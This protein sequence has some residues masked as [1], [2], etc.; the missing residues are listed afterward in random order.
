MRLYEVD[1]RGVL[2]LAS[3]ALIALGLTS[4]ALTPAFAQE[5]KVLRVSQ[6][7]DASTMD[8]QMQGSMVDTSVLINMF[9]MLTYRAD[10]GQ[11]VPGLAT[12]W[13]AL[14]DTTWRFKLRDD[15]NFHNGEPFNAAAVKFSIDRIIKP[16]TK[17]PIVELRSVK[18][19]VVVDE[20]TVDVITT[21]PDPI[22]P[23]KLSLFG[24]VMIPPAYVTEVGDEGFAAHPIGTGPF[25]FVEWQRNQ[26]VVMEAN[27][28]Y[29]DGRPAIDK[30]IFRPIPDTS[31]ALAAI[32]AGELD[33]VAGLSADAAAQITGDPEINVVAETGVRAFF[34]VL[35]TINGGPLT[36]KRVRQ[37]LNHA[38]N[39]PEL[40]EALYGG[41]AHQISTLVARQSFGFDPSLAPYEHDLEKAKSLLAEAGY[42]DGFTVNL[43]AQSSNGDF[44][45]AISG[46]LAQVGVTA[47][48]QLHDGGNFSAMTREN[49]AAALSPMWFQ[50]ATG[51][52]MDAAS[53]FQSYIKPDRVFSQ[54][55]NP[56]ASAL[57][58]IGEQSVDPAVR[59]EAYNKLQALLIE[60]APFLF[61]YQID[62]LYAVKSNVTWNANAL[63]ILRMAKADIN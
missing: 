18:E 17:S 38:I 23:A 36:D 50:G 30:L 28:D 62:N 59:Q 40:T 22:I 9:D 54:Y 1:R 35:D 43:N 14:D 42:A 12:S 41:Y 52:T 21:T 27:D 44:V 5:E 24:G 60:D 7:A 26:Q 11:L 29:W 13:E 58:D 10:D 16:D 51:W 57:V 34:V 15:V 3:V 8:P 37:A 61:L 49:N 25:K 20:F 63:G 2:R 47:N 45:Q 46:Q 31:S 53:A 56:E 32:Q 33:I 55:N 48:V 4:T 39:V 19:V 6:T